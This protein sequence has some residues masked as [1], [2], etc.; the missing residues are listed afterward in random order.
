[1]AD[2]GRPVMRRKEKKDNETTEIKKE[3]K[4]GGNN[5]EADASAAEA[6]APNVA[7]QNGQNGDFQ[8]EPM[9]LPP[10]EIITG[11]VFFTCFLKYATILSICKYA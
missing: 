7:G 9:E 2:K 1:M 10:F 5:D 6:V 4:N 11:Y 3:V 8:V